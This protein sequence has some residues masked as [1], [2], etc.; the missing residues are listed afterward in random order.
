M[1]K[2]NLE[3]LFKETFT[4]FHEVPDERVWESI[5]AS[6]DKKD[7]KRIVPFWWRMGGVAALLA[8]LFYVINPFDNTGNDSQ[9]LITDIENKEEV[10]QND[11]VSKHSNVQE[12]T[13]S[14]NEDATNNPKD[15]STENYE[16]TDGSLNKNQSIKNAQ[17]YAATDVFEDE[18]LPENKNN[19]KN[20]LSH[21]I[22][23]EKTKQDAQGVASDDSIEK[24]KPVNEN[25]AADVL[26]FPTK[27]QTD[28]IAVV[29]DQDKNTVSPPNTTKEVLKKEGILQNEKENEGIAENKKQSIFDAIAQ[30]EEETVVENSNN[31]R[32]SVGPSVAPVYFGSTGE[33]SPIHSNFAS[34]SKSGSVNLSYGVTVAYDVGKRLKVRS[35]V[36]KV[37]F[38]YDTNGIS[39]SSS[40]DGSTNDLIDNISYNQTSRNLVLQS[41]TTIP[42]ASDADTFGDVPFLEISANETP[43]VDGNLVQ[44]LGYIEVPLELSYALVDK[45]FG[46]NL[47]GGISSLF[48]IEGDNSIVLEAENLVTEVGEAN[49]ANSLN[50][51]TN[52]G[53]GLNYEFS[54]K[55]QLNIEPVFKYQLNTFSE[56]AGTFNPFSVGVYSGVSFRF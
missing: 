5:E 23:V 14:S 1:G 51:S 30:Q 38:G 15:T 29:K 8:I 12:L 24:K 32:W 21:G 31:G 44:Q 20:N 4:G 48:L 50:F 2:K 3:Q 36:H 18:G 39:A 55:V 54:P 53:I 22:D 49:N 35:G 6:L 37:N 10:H 27:N 26:G 33:G 34:N 46:L 43:G 56:T 52:I 13:N 42:D 17:E 9:I 25:N 28:A 45:K 16:D 19:P 47:I 41:K 11:S 40:L 7:K